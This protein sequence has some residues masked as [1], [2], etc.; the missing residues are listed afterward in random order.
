MKKRAFGKD[1]TEIS[2]LGFGAGGFWGMNVFDEGVARSLVDLALDLGF[3]MFDTGPNYSNAN[4]ETRLGR[5]LGRRVSDVF[6]GTKGGTH[7]RSGR[8]VK[9]Y[10]CAGLQASFEQSLR[11][12]GRDSVDLYQLHDMP[13]VLSDETRRFI[14]DLKASG[15]ARYLGVSTDSRGADRAVNEDIF[16]VVMIEYN[17]LER[18]LP[19]K[20]IARAREQ[21]VG[22][23][24]KSPLAK[25]LY[26]RDIFKVRSLSDLWYLARAY[27]NNR[28][29]IAHGRK[30]RFV[31]DHATPL[32]FVLANEGVT[33]AIIGTTK[34]SHLRA[35]ALASETAID[36]E[37][38]LRLQTVSEGREAAN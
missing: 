19:E 6:I 37:M 30:F 22:V 27:K 33:S 3:T 7:Y 13:D 31:T 17:I 15:K 20:T 38:L 11:R 1:G 32:Q 25:T 34:L 5:I 14:M 21:S 28:H 29:K 35:N 4:A 16:D 36:P 18:K 12:L 26:S 9:D 23:L 8:H 24:V 2:E 10:S